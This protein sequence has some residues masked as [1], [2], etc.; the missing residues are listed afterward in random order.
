MTIARMRWIACL[1]AV[2]AVGSTPAQAADSLAPPGAKWNWLPKDD[3]V[4]KHWLPYDEGLL[5]RILDMSREDVRRYFNG[6]KRQTV[7]PLA[8]VARTKGYSA[9]R[10]ALR[11]V[12]AWH[13]KTSKRKFAVLIDHAT[14]S[15]TQGHLMQHML[16]H[17]FHNRNVFRA[18]MDIFGVSMQ[19]LNI[20]L[21]QGRSRRQIGRQHGR[22][23]DQ[24]RAAIRQALEAT[25]AR[26]VQL[27][28]TPKAEAAREV[29]VA[30][31]AL[32]A[33]LD[34]SGAGATDPQHPD[35]AHHP[36]GARTAAL[37]CTLHP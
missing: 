27:K 32:E 24:M 9:R 15:L 19:E 35:H 36:K 26:G 17:P 2:A 10:L 14:R 11:L 34:E 5:F 8:N 6:D 7:A 13:P 12:R 22:T 28:L 30:L 29:A 16:F 23:D 1:V 18:S 3:W 21:T 25:Q 20:Q 37:R 31:G 33:W 4:H